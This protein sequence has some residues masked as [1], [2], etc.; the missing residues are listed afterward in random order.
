[1]TLGMQRIEEHQENGIK[2]KKN[3]NGK[4]KN[5]TVI[6]NIEFLRFH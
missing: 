1:M 5:E 3:W 4:K 2:L 6:F